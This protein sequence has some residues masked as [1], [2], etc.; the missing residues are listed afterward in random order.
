MHDSDEARIGAVMTR[1]LRAVSFKAGDQPRYAKLPALFSPHARLIRTSG[2]A[3]EISTLVAFV[4]ARRY[5]FDK[6]ELRA[7]SEMKGPVF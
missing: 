4:R 1:F 6:G 5:A 7:R 3:P 2:P